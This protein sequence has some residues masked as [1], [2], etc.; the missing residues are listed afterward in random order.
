MFVE[1]RIFKNKYTYIHKYLNKVNVYKRIYMKAF[2][3][4]Q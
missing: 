2:S 4:V 3:S 1:I